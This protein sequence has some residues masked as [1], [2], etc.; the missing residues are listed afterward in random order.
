MIFR[1]L[2]VAAIALTVLVAGGAAADTF[3]VT[4]VSQTSSTITLG[5][6]PQPGYGYLFSANGTLVSRTNDPS[7]SQV[8]FAKANTYEVAVI[9]KGAIG[10]YPTEPPPPPKAAC[11]NSLD[12]DGDG[13]IDYP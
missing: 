6:T 13:K 2:A 10:T 3:T 4:L 8:K 11:E 1:A 12:D 9:V 5:W 7:R